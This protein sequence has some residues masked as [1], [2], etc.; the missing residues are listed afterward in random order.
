MNNVGFLRIRI[1]DIERCFDSN[2]V[3]EVWITFPDPQ[4]KRRRQSKRLTHP[5]F[6]KRYNSFLS[7]EAIINLKTDSA[8]LYGYTLGIIEGEDH[9]LLDCTNDLYNVHQKRENLEIKTHYEN[10]YLE[11]GTPITYTKFRL[12]Y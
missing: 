2:E 11:R 9:E 8:F 10:I 7:K 1:E 12:R 6:L 5:S 4:I 3:D